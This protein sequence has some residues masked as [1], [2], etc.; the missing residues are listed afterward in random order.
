MVCEV[1][2]YEKPTLTDP[3]LIEGLP[4]IGFVANIAAL[5]LIQELKAKSF[6]EIRSSFFQDLAITAEN[7]KPHFPI[8]Q[9]YYHKGRDGE[10][11]L[12][13][14]Y[15]NTQALT[16]VGQYELCGR[17]LDV[18]EELGCRYVMT[19]GG[20]KR[21]EKVERPELYCAAS[22]RETLQDALGLGAKIIGGR[23]FGVAGLL[24]GLGRLRGMRGFCLLAETPGVYPDAVAAREVL[25]AVCRMLHLKVNLSRLDTAA[26]ATNNI[27]KAFGVISPSIEE[28][29]REPK[30]RWLI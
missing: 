5:H 30:F 13:I 16:T 11:D 26:E 12:I 6:A 28:R 25:K 23:I 9:L 3:V 14:L 8:N 18:A 24:I 17:I 27:L 19:L 10:R 20:L 7:E 22:D 21:E 1:Q 29:K 15:G 2:I 4:G